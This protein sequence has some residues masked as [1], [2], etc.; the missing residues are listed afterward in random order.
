MRSR[1]Q[2]IPYGI[3]MGLVTT[4]IGALVAERWG[5]LARLAVWGA[6]TATL[7]VGAIVF[8]DPALGILSRLLRL[9]RS[10]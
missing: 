3:A 2:L 1:L 4:A 5:G 9:T 8:A 7:A 10:R 6:V